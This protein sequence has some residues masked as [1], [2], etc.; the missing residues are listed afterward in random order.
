[1]SQFW[2]ILILL[3]VGIPS[4]TLFALLPMYGLYTFHKRKMEQFRLQ[5]D[6]LLS[7]HIA[8]E[9]DSVREE[10]KALRDTSMQYDL[11]FDTALHQ[12]ER[13]V[14]GLERETYHAPSIPPSQN[15]TLGGR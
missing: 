12:M 3:L 10:I 15:I 6:N 14:N 1:M 9:F 2:E 8:N 7:Q 13:R 11:S 5:R 4:V